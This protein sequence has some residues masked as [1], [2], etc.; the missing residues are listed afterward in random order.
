MEM[1]LSSRAPGQNPHAK[2]L[3]MN[4]TRIVAI[5]ISTGRVAYP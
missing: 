1:F 3:A 5:I 2:E 4:W